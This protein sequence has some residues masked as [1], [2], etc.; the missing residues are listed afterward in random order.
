MVRL[1]LLTKS[2]PLWPSPSFTFKGQVIVT[3][4]KEFGELAVGGKLPDPQQSHSFFDSPHHHLEA[5]R[6]LPP[7]R[8]NPAKTAMTTLPLSKII[9]FALLF[10]QTSITVA[11]QYSKEMAARLILARERMHL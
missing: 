10:F 2:R 1:Q 7:L 8:S 6:V 11:Q 9:V 4:D 5:S 3:F